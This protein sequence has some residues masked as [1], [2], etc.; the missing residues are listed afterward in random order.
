MSLVLEFSLLDLVF[1]VFMYIFMFVCI[2][3]VHCLKIDFVV[4]ECI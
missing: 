2:D 4:G 3:S 1:N